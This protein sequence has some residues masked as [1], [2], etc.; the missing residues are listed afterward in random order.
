MEKSKHVRDNADTT[1]SPSE[2]V[3]IAEVDFGDLMDLR[4]HGPDTFMGLSP[5]YPWGRLFGGQVI[6]QSLRAAQLSVADS[7]NI[8]SLHAYFIRGGTHKEP[9]RFEV[10]RIRNGRSFVTR[11]VVARQS[12]G[13]I[14]NLSC[15]FQVTEAEA[16]VQTAQ[17]PLEVPGPESAADTGWGQGLLERRPVLTEHA[18]TLTWVKL[19]AADITDPSLMACAL[20]FMS[21]SV[22]TGGVRSAHPIQVERSKVRET[23]VG[24][25]LDHVVY[26]Q[27]LPTTL[28]QWFLADVRCHGL[29]GGRGVSVG[30]LYDP[31]G[32][33]VL[34]I[35][36]EVLLRQRRRETGGEA[37][38]SGKDI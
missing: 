37:G 10:D 18:H 25:S 5:R 3:P 27:R 28:D 20:A 38:L 33:Q 31:A 26:F 8:H 9:V 19:R 35:V 23:F 13:A 15:S 24:A 29:V 30:D 2:P 6:A 14:L 36:Q 22:P 4:K 16:D 17:P 21:D 1:L 7:Y 12:S 34:T 32:T 11:R